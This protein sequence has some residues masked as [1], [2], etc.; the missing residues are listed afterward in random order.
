VA[1]VF[2]VI[3]GPDPS[4]T[5]TLGAP[6][7]ACERGL[8]GD[9]RKT[10]IACPQTFYRDG[11]DSDVA[12]A[13]RD[14]EKTM[15]SLGA[16]L[17][18]TTAPD[19]ERLNTLCRFVLS[20]E[21]ATLHRTWLQERSQDYADQVRA[22]LEPGLFYPATR[23]VEALALREPLT[24][25]WLQTVIGEADC[26]ILPILS[27]SVPSIADTTQGSP[28]EISRVIARITRNT[29]AVNYLG[30][31][32]IAVPCGFSKNGLPIAVQIVGRRWTEPLLLK[33]ADAFQRV[34]DWHLRTPPGLAEMDLWK[35]SKV[36]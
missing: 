20:V 35:P 17:K 2:D 14:F 34:T 30:L 1:R 29:G 7:G 13:M 21:G 6:Q 27:S 31:P 36:A 18:E 10:V 19:I 32:A 8:D 16:T 11:L 25:E 4:D 15:Q 9:I 33:I 26:A 28:A 22:R 12:A 24:A 3:A 5:D 23:Y